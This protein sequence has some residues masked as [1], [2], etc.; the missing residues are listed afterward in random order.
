MRQCSLAELM[1]GMNCLL[2][3]TSHAQE[4]PISYLTVKS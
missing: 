2:S 3:D 4:L 1:F